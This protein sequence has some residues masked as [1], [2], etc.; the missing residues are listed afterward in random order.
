MAKNTVFS[1]G[2]SSSGVPLGGRWGWGRCEIYPL[3]P[4][5]DGNLWELSGGV[6]GGVSGWRNVRQ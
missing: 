5:E 2:F 6:D 3:S 1:D 4:H